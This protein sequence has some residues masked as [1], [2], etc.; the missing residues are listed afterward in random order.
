MKIV[1]YAEN[2]LQFERIGTIFQKKEKYFLINYLEVIVSMKILSRFNE[3]DKE[4]LDKIIRKNLEYK[5][6]LLLEWD[7][8]QTEIFFQQS[9]NYI[10]SLP[11]HEFKAIRVQDA[12]AAFYIKEKFPWL[13]IQLILENN[14]HNLLS[15]ER[16][17][18]F[19]GNQLERLILS[20]ELSKEHLEKYKNHLRVD[21]EILAFGRILLFY[22][23][24]KLLTPLIKTEGGSEN[25]EAFGKS[26]ES[27]HSGFPIIE[28]EHG[29]FMFN[30]KDLSLL[31]DLDELRE[32]KITAARLDL[33]FDSG[34]F[35]L[36]N[37]LE[38]FFKKNTSDDMLELKKKFPRPFIKGF[39]KINKTNILFKKLK[40]L[41]IQR[42]DQNYVGE[43]LD[44]E[45]K[46]QMLLMIKTKEIDFSNGG[47]FEFITPQGKRKSLFLN[48]ITNTSGEKLEKGFHNDVALL[49]FVTGVVTKTQVYLRT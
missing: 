16:W 46:H 28:N 10:E 25:I 35:F 23:P 38:S 31:E 29:T 34:F 21:L 12:G 5:I 19:F 33:R 39:Y 14:N 2:A 6:P 40:N 9:K 47:E 43:I 37:L 1:L 30:V 8:L 41:S 24:R 11:L 15:L 7:L 44:V 48:K 36:E 49:P 4:E 20:N 22:S 13:K 17:S 27:P 45:K 3:S 18:N 26:E 42:Q 32:I